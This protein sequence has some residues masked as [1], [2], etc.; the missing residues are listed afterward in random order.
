MFRPLT[1][2]FRRSRKYPAAA[3][4]ILLSCLA[5]SIASASDWQLL[6]DEDLANVGHLTHFVDRDTVKFEGRIVSAWILTNYGTPQSM[7]TT[8]GEQH[9]RSVKSLVYINCSTHELASAAELDY[10]KTM[11][12]GEALGQPSAALPPDSKDLNWSSPEVW[13][14][15]DKQ[16]RLL[17]KDTGITYS[18]AQSAKALSNVALSGNASRLEISPAR[19]D[20]LVAAVTPNKIPKSNT[21][22]G[23][24]TISLRDPIRPTKLGFFPI[25]NPADFAL[26]PD[27]KTAYVI[28]SR[29]GGYPQDEK[30]YGLFVVDISDPSSPRLSNYVEGSF[31]KMGLIN[32]GAVLLLQENNFLIRDNLADADQDK[33]RAY[34]LEGGMPKKYCA[35]AFSEFQEAGK[36]F[37]YSF[38]TFSDSDNIA[39]SNRGAEL[40]FYDMTSVCEPRWLTTIPDVDG[41][42]VVGWEKGRLLGG[43]QGLS[44]FN[45]QSPVRWKG[46]GSRGASLSNI[47][48]FAEPRLA[49]AMDVY[50]VLVFG[51][52]DE[53][54]FW[55]RESYH[56]RGSIEA[57]VGPDSMLYVG[58]EN[59]VRSVKM[60]PTH[61][62][63]AI[64]RSCD[65]GG[66]VP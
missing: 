15:V 16:S 33:I 55:K 7:S 50:T 25:L 1:V 5:Y 57:V 42:D 24:Y 60:G 2:H 28:S 20:I 8:D 64:H 49:T 27:G 12:G 11:G 4:A 38:L 22:Y 58:G 3:C 9:Y 65:N 21:T 6:Y 19:K 37:A 13:E 53:G 26:S 46:Y 10:S 47:R 32:K 14:F 56:M 45:Y 36:V 66:A 39:I 41:A 40:R 23:L 29:G 54:C 51:L 59:W 62:R 31:F 43:Q 52:D 44:S 17:C 48:V 63:A 30:Y 35:A 18:P 61:A 34:L